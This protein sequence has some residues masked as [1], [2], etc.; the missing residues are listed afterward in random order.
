MIDL[1]PWL[2]EWALV[3]IYALAVITALVLINMLRR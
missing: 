1:L 3:V 2:R